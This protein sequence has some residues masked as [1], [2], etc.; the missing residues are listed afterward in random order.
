MELVL[1]TEVHANNTAVDLLLLEGIKIEKEVEILEIID[2]EMME[3]PKSEPTN[4][5]QISFFKS[6]LL[7]PTDLQMHLLFQLWNNKDQNPRRT[8]IKKTLEILVKSHLLKKKCSKQLK[9]WKTRIRFLTSLELSLPTRTS[10]TFRES[11]QNHVD[12]R[13]CGVMQLKRK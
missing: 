2:Q 6:K 5:N 4:N 13:T 12:M 8:T 3:H 7:V 10:F 1:E 9:K 11:S